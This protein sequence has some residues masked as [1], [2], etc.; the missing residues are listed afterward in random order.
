[1]A[2]QDF[3]DSIRASCPDEDAWNE[4]YLCRPSSGQTSLLPYPLIEACED[5]AGVAVE[6]GATVGTSA[7][8][9]RPE[10]RTLNPLYAGFDV[11]RKRDVSVLWVLERVGDVFWTRRVQVLEDVTFTAQEQLLHALL[12]DRSVKRLCVD[13]TGIGAMLAERLSHRWGHRAEAVHFS[14]PVKAELALPLRRL[15]QDRLV[16]VPADPAIRADLHKVRK[17]VTASH[18]LRLDAPRDADGHADRFWALAL[19]YHASDAAR[20]R[21]SLPTVTGDRPAGW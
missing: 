2:R 13:A 1:V 17:I 9:S 6:G 14:A 20:G 15:F 21:S 16:R 12:A 11:G 4:E 3:I 7:S 19:A 18:N 8:P 5:H 10:P